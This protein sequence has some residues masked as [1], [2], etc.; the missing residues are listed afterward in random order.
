MGD[1]TD[2]RSHT[3]RKLEIGELADA[4]ST[5]IADISEGGICF[6]SPG[7]L[8]SGVTISIG[9]NDQIV[10]LVVLRCEGGD[11][12]YRIRCQFSP[13]TNRAD[14]DLLIDQLEPAAEYSSPDMVRLFYW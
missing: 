12:P 1:M 5:L 7:I 4:D 10:Q 8:D 6:L 11:S 13:A 14:I 2:H 3:R 9:L